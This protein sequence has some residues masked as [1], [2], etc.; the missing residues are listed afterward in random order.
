MEK[1]KCVFRPQIMDQRSF[2]RG[3]EVYM[4][5]L[6]TRTMVTL[7]MLSAVAFLAAWF[8]KINVFNFLSLEPKDTILAITGFLFGPGAALAASAVVALAE[9]LFV[10]STGWIGLIMNVLSSTAF[11][12]TAA[13][14][15]KQD[16]TQKGAI[17]GLVSGTLLMT[18]V[19]LLWNY[20][21]TPLYMNMPREDV[22]SLLPTVFL[23]FNLVKGTLN[24]GLILLLYKPLVRSLRM[25]H[26]LPAAHSERGEIRKRSTYFAVGLACLLLI[27][28]L[29]FILKWRNP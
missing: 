14:V 1:E 27:V 18:A 12:V 11:A 28:S 25:T 24:T 7:S 9:F 26:L 15:Y 21:I 16:R 23:P 10:S 29:V 4:K 2:F 20:L 13:W 3:K 6:D 5:K 8:I 22:A 19:M 17:L